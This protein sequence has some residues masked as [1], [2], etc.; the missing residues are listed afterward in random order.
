M[1]TKTLSLLLLLLCVLALADQPVDF[2]DAR[3]YREELLRARRNT[4]SFGYTSTETLKARLTR[5]GRVPQRVG[6]RGIELRSGLDG[7][8]GFTS[9]AAGLAEPRRRST[10]YTDIPDMPVNEEVYASSFNQERPSCCMFPDRSFVT[11]WEDERNGDLDIFIQK[12]TFEGTAQ[13]VNFE[14]GEED[15]PKDQYLPRVSLLSDTS[16]I[17]VWIDE[18]SFAIYGRIFAADMSPLTDA[19]E[20][21]DSPLD[22]STWSPAVSCGSKGEFVVVWED[23]RSGSNIH[24]RRFDLTGNPL[25]ASFRAN[26]DD[27]E[28]S[29]MVPDVSADTSGAFAVVWEDFRN[30]DGDVYAQRFGP[31]GAKLGDNVLVN[32][33]SL[34][35]DQYT[36]SVSMGQDGRFVVAWVDLRRTNASVFARSLRFDDPESDTVFFSVGI[37]AGSVTQEGPRVVSDTLGRF[38]VSW[39]EYTVSDRTNYV[40]RFDDLG[41]ALG[42]AIVIGDL[43]STG[44]LHGLT[45]SASPGGSLVAVWMDRQTGNYDIYARTVPAFGIPQDPIL[46]LNDD[47]WGANQSRPRIATRADGGFTVV[48]EDM[49]RGTPDVFMKRFDQDAQSLGSDYMV[50][51]S[52]TRVY[53]GNPDVASDPNGN[54]AVVWEDARGSSLDIYVQLFDHTGSPNGLNLKVNST[55][56]P[57]NSTPR[58][59]MSP[60]GGL[61]VVW[62]STNG[63]TRDIYGR[64]F[65]ST[66]L[67]VDTCFKIN[68]DDLTVNH[69]S[70]AIATDSAGRFVVAWQDGREGQDRVYL[71]RFA[72]D[73]TR[74]G[75][76]FP[77]YT[78]RLNP[79][80]YNPDLDLNQIGEFVVSWTEP[81]AYFTMIYAQ[82]Y[83]TS[84]SPIDTNIMVADDASAFPG[85]SQVKLADDGY[86]AVVWTGYG[87]PDSDIYYR[88]FL[89]A[90][91]QGPSYLV[92]TEADSLLQDFPDIDIWNSHLLSVW[93]DNR[94]PG[95]GFSIFFNRI[96]YA[97][98]DVSDEEESQILPVG[99]RLDQNYPNPFN[100]ATVIKYFISP[101]LVRGYNS[102]AVHVTLVVYNLLGQ[103]VSTLVDEERQSGEHLVT[104]N[105]KDERGEKVSSGVYLYRLK[106]GDQAVTRRLILLK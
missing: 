94:I 42:D 7:K 64:L 36:P 16:F 98:T 59:A 100:P 28:W 31:G 88:L 21:S 37:Q 80:Q 45:L 78:D 61:V 99:F 20:V 19:F 23:T 96:D 29:R 90:Q 40:R 43:E 5:F 12:Y 74:I 75:V 63:T 27:L 46:I 101:D 71:Q 33:D 4:E 26:D 55:D 13:G 93:R 56:T 72:A 24:V 58:C 8:V 48:W 44:E 10:G 103:R 22:F 77:V 1:K 76:N 53:R 49:R 39:T 2:K 83:D 69:L 95:M 86:T 3:F 104:W 11:V 57:A 30:T 89:G 15:F 25:G 50:N 70:P 73:C 17:V 82:R 9:E 54:L 62:S 87:Y 92:N 34:N 38:T 79:L 105:G 18:E 51:D 66:G 85:G 97:G 106:V 35:E 32:A 102:S 65:Y 81:Y 91:P 6:S 47:L 41:N 60:E 67:P 84:G 52:T 68:D 14:A